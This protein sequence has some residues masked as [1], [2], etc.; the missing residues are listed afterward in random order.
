M[1][2]VEFVKANISRIAELFVVN[3]GKFEVREIGVKSQGGAYGRTGVTIAEALELTYYRGR[4]DGIMEM[5]NPEFH[6]GH[7]QAIALLLKKEVDG[8]QNRIEIATGPVAEAILKLR[9]GG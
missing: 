9:P 4:I 2:V 5:T 7:Q 8:K 1:N 3:G 6:Q